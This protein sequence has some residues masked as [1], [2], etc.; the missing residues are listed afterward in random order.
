[1]V[2]PSSALVGYNLLERLHHSLTNLEK[3]QV[4]QFTIKLSG[5]ANSYAMGMP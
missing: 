5:I 3:S 2:N 4:S 1:V